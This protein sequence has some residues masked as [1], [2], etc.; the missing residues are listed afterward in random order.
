M[1]NSEVDMGQLDC[2]IL[3]PMLGKKT[4]E[5]PSKSV[6][7]QIFKFGAPLPTPSPDVG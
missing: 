2:Y 7:C 3:S 4:A 1:A 6:T 5:I